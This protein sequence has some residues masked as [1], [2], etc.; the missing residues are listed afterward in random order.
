M[1]DTRLTQVLY[2]LETT[3]L[4]G[5][6]GDIILSC[7][8][9]DITDRDNWTTYNLAHID[10][11]E[12]D[13][14][15]ASDI[16]DELNKYDR[17][18]AWNSHGFDLKFLNDRLKANRLRPFIHRGSFDMKEYCKATYSY[19]GGSQDEW[20][21]ALDCVHQKTPL[22]IEQNRRIGRGEGTADDWKE[23]LYHN[24][25]DV[26]GMK[27]IYDWLFPRDADHA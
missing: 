6:N 11:P 23:L 27:E 18:I 19:I 24:D 20:L 13:D 10:A 16:R 15:I 26:K 7:T 12:P 1:K 3:G 4:F 14:I 21:K 5:G 2:D 8:F 9:L 22:D 17:I 25:E